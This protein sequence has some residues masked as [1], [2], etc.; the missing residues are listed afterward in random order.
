MNIL[1]SPALWFSLAA[2]LV[3]IEIL[4]GAMIAA[5][6]SAGC[7]VSG[8]MALLG[9]GP[10]ALVVGLI[11]GTLAAFVSVVPLIKHFRSRNPKAA[12]A[13]SGME[14]LTGREACVTEAIEDG[15]K[16]RVR[17]DGDNWQ[18]RSNSG[19]SVP[20]GTKVRVV[21]HESIVLIVEVL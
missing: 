6:L 7:L 9:F 2:L 11:A 13:V 10:T 18:A 3:I 16:G 5:C 19:C 17:I 1:S 21:G 12:A 4:S 14:A 15:G 20:A 8:I